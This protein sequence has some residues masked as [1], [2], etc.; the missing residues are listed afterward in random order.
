MSGQDN[1]IPLQAVEPDDSECV[2]KP[3]VIKCVNDFA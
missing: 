1:A 2:F 3:N